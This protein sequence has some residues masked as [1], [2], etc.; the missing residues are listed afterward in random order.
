M[1]KESTFGKFF[2]GFSDF[3]PLP[4]FSLL[5]SSYVIIEMDFQ[6]FLI[7]NEID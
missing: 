4:S 3:V 7:K 6:E 2:N 5:S 1:I